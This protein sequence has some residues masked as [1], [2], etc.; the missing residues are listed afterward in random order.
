M[1]PIIFTFLDVSKCHFIK[2]LGC[3]SLIFFE[4]IQ[5]DTLPSTKYPNFGSHLEGKKKTLKYNI[6]I[7]NKFRRSYGRKSK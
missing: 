2:Q 3:L 6:Q 7:R 5:V 1:R 4:E